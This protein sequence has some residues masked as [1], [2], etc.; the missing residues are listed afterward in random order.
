MNFSPCR[1]FFIIASLIWVSLEKPKDKDSSAGQEDK[2]NPGHPRKPSGKKRQER[3]WAI[4]PGWDEVVRTRRSG[5]DTGTPGYKISLLHPRAETVVSVGLRTAR[6]KPH[7]S[8]QKHC[9]TRLDLEASQERWNKFLPL[10]T[11]EYNGTRKKKKVGFVCFS[12]NHHHHCI[13]L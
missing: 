8:C 12:Y 11:M 1:P 2:E 6:Q 13:G 4:M 9:H 5:Q 3:Q 10:L 7:F